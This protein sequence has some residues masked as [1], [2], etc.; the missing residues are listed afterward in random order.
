M[1]Q[2]LMWLW[3]TSYSLVLSLSM[4]L[5]FRL[6]FYV[7]ELVDGCLSDCLSNFSFVSDFPNFQKHNL[8]EQSSYM[9]TDATNEA[10]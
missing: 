3:A 6:H 1:L 10:S 5:N 2:Y 8:K 9:Q 4:Y 7:P